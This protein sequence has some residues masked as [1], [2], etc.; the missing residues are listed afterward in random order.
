MAGDKGDN[1]E[2]ISNIEVKYLKD[3]EGKIISPVVSSESVFCPG[4]DAMLKDKINA[5]DSKLVA[6]S[7][8]KAGFMSAA[9]KTKLDGITTSADSVSF[10]R[11]LTA[12]T[13]VGDLTINGTTTS[14]YAPTPSSGLT[15]SSYTTSEHT[16]KSSFILSPSGEHSEEVVFYNDGWYPLS[17]AGVPNGD[18]GL[19]RI[20]IQAAGKGWARIYFTMKNGDPGANRQGS[21]KCHI[22]WA[23]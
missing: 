18:L 17:V 5:I 6:A 23:K 20:N 15:I 22:L 9:D 10:T 19:K 14:L 2:T 12:G 3:N 1:Y 4:E 8:S 16:C 13:K 7:Q 11:S 21:L